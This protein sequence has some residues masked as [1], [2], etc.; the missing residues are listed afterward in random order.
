MGGWLQVETSISCATVWAG[1]V[2]PKRYQFPIVP[3]IEVGAIL[4]TAHWVVINF[5]VTPCIKY[6]SRYASI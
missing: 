5:E 6:I 4:V 1:G 2:L 3:S